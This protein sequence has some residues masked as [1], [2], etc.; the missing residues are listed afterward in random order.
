M[1]VSLWAKGAYSLRMGD[2]LQDDIA[3][4]FSAAT[5]TVATIVVLTSMLHQYQYS[6]AVIIYLWIALI[7]FVTAGRWTFRGLMGYLHRRGIAVRRLLVVGATDVGK[8]IMQSVA[9]RRDL[10]YELVGFVDTD[11]G[12]ATRL[13][14]QSGKALTDFGRFR[15]LGS[16]ADAPDILSREHVDE[17]II[18]V[19][20]SAHE[21]IGRSCTSVRPRELGLSWFPTCSS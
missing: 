6:R 12:L 5:I 3:S 19:P 21:E 14:S 8:M 16:V 1:L 17:V 7:V 11:N 18:A 13:P 20:A 4:A 2:E 9:G 10:G 15:N